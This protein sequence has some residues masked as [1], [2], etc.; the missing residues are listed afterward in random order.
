[1]PF[2]HHSFTVLVTTLW[3]L[4]ENMNLRWLWGLDVE[5]RMGSTGSRGG[6]L[7]LCAQKPYPFFKKL[8]KILSVLAVMN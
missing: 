5:T 2:S 3:T 8:F 6:V 1:M 4:K 7:E